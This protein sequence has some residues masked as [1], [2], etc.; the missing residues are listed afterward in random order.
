MTDPDR[1]V[2]LVLRSTRVV[3]PDGTRP[4][5]VAVTGG[6][7]TA[8]L[9]HGRGY[10]S[11]LPP[12]ARL[13]D[14]G[15]D[16]VLPGLVDTH[17]HVNDPGRAEWEGFWTATRAAASGGITT[18]IDMPLN[19]LPPTTTTAHLRIKREVAAP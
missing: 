5:S 8:V 9:P 3:T 15:D 17:V 13:E 10:G 16:V 2:D 6:T 19:S 11:E 4:A 1:N 18:L 12:G 7:I 14:V